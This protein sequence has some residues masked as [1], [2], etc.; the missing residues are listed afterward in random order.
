MPNPII[1]R[2]IILTRPTG[3]SYDSDAQ[4]YFNELPTQPSTSNKNKINQL[5]VNAKANGWYQLG[6]ILFL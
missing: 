3:V 1:N 6:E 2:R 4:A 5:F